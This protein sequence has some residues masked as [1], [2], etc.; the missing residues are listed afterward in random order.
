MSWARAVL[1]QTWTYHTTAQCGW[2]EGGQAQVQ[3]TYL[4]LPTF[5]LVR[6]LFGMPKKL[7]ELPQLE[8]VQVHDWV[9][10]IGHAQTGRWAS[11]STWEELG[12]AQAVLT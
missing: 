1:G 9:S 3:P 10:L 5:L 8:Y 4:G 2:A 12:L 11:L 6:V 7:I